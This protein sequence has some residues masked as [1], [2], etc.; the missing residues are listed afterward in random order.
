MSSVA[1]LA[2]H[3]EANA[4]SWTWAESGLGSGSAPDESPSSVVSVIFGGEESAD[5]FKLKKSTHSTNSVSSRSF[6][7]EKNTTSSQ[8]FRASCSKIQHH[9][10]KE[11]TEILSI[12]IAA[13]SRPNPLYVIAIRIHATVERNL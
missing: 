10:E 9:H 5:D 8:N 2:S 4:V 7:S 12:S 6:H 11:H 1:M 13:P 3:D